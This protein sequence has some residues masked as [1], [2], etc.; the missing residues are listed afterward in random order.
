LVDT[1][2]DQ[3]AAADGA[4][5]GSRRMDGTGMSG[6]CFR[7]PAAASAAI[8]AAVL[9]LALPFVTLGDVSAQMVVHILAMSVVA[10]VVATLGV[11][12]SPRRT[13][14]ARQLW[15][16][17]AGQIILLWGWHLPSAHHFAAA[18]PVGALV[19]HLSLLAVAV[20]FW[21]ALVQQRA[22][23]QWHGI[24]AL[25]VTGKLACLLAALLVFA[26]QPLFQHR[27]AAAALDDQQLAG[28]LMIVACPAS[29]V[30][31]A[32]IMAARFVG[33]AQAWPQLH[34]D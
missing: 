33:V 4:I 15:L 1:H 14:S 28:L 17:T 25:L 34:A 12:V 10:P 13:V 3:D 8:V 24:L 23:R 9:A 32:V 27:A 31:A 7:H 26:T 2:L 18:S 29:Y 20:W 19:M 6:L 21:D 5:E 22:D 16:A 30:L 11:L